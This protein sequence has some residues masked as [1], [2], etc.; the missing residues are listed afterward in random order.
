MV[1]GDGAIFQDELLRDPLKGA[2]EAALRLRQAV[3][4]Y[5]KDSPWGT[6]QVPII[7][8][9]FV[10]LTGLAKSLA[11][12]KVIEVESQM[13]LFAELFTNSRAEFDFVNV[14][15]GKENADSKMRS[16]FVLHEAPTPVLLTILPRNAYPLLQ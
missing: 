15:H 11:S 1:D 10:N 8:R 14:G 16:Q 4:G 9:V 5:L 3:R 7:V 13:R 6:D 12:A 2:P